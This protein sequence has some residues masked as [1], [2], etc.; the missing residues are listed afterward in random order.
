MVCKVG[1]EKKEENT[2]K[3]SNKILSPNLQSL[4]RDISLFSTSIL[5]NSLNPDSHTKSLRDCI[6]PQ[7]DAPIYT[8]HSIYSSNK[9]IG[10]PPTARQDRS[11]FLP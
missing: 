2:P 9:V 7:M 5:K 1:R 6:F 8:S 10:T 3:I 11:I 4:L